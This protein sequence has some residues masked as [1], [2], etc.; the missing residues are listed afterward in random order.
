MKALPFLSF[1]KQS[2]SWAWVYKR[3]W[4]LGFFIATTTIGFQFWQDDSS[5]LS[6]V[7]FFKDGFSAFR[8]DELILLGLLFFVVVYLLSLIAKASILLGLK[9]VKQNEEY[10]V[11]QL[12]K[13]GFRKIPR[14][15]LLEIYLGIINIVLA[16][17]ISLYFINTDS[18]MMAVIFIVAMLLMLFYNAILYLCKH[19]AYCYIVFEDKSTWQS[20]VAAWRLSRNNLKNVI[21]A[22]LVEIALVIAVMAILVVIF[23]VGS[24]IVVTITTLSFLYG[25]FIIFIILLAFLAA[26][27]L[28]FLLLCVKAFLSTFFQGFMTQV[29]WALNDKK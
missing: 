22:K 11:W 9:K 16:V 20:I 4:I 6:I 13:F 25:G 17:I 5:D 8:F 2:L 10:K 7:N 21:L 28:L 29:Y 27:A 23:F 12:I 24:A 14:T 15:L 26:V 1:I 18:A 3:L 19:Y